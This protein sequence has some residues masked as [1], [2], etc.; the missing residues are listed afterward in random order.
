M[1]EVVE[2]VLLLLVFSQVVIYLDIMLHQMGLQQ[3]FLLT[4]RPY[5]PLL[6]VCLN[7]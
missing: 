3:E 6:I 1:K 4:R 2:E 7:R 5:N